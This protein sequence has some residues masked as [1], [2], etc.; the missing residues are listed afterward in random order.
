MNLFSL[1]T[2]KKPQQK[3]ELIDGIEFKFRKNSLSKSLRITLKD[4]N[5]VLVTLPK[6]ASF[7]VARDFAIKSLPEIKK[8]LPFLKTSDKNEIEKLR[9]IAKEYL[10]KRLE[11]LALR[12]G[13]KYG[14][15]TVKRLK[16]RW[17]SCSFKNNINFS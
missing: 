16:T 14:K 12:F 5:S 8:S 1:L 7:K 6:Y 3:V 13:Y 17:G 10:P 9:K 2:K 11:E 15:V 4:K